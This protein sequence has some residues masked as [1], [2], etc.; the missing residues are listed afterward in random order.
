MLE[1]FVRF[2]TSV[3][4]AH[5]DLKRGYSFSD[6]ILFEKPEDV[7]EHFGLEEC[8][9]LAQDNFEETSGKW[10][11]ALA[12]L[13]G[14]GPFDN[15]E[16]AEDYIRL[17]RGYNGVKYPVAVIFKGSYR[18]DARNDEGDCFKPE[19]ITKTINLK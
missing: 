2:V 17:N 11:I 3:E 12:G 19:T 8:E 1:Y 18:E 16:E 15:L 5:A 14:F 6:Y 9:D 4:Q 13:C 7:L 10:G